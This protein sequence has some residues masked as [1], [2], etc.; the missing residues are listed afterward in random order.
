MKYFIKPIAMKGYVLLCSGNG[1][2]GD[3]ISLQMPKEDAEFI[4]KATNAYMPMV[5]A[6]TLGVHALS[7]FYIPSQSVEL[8]TMKLVLNGVK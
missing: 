5:D 4:V 1:K 7:E 6:L 2:P 3:G 8:Q